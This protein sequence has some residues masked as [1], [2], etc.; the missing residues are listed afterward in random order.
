MLRKCPA[1]TF[2]LIRTFTA[3]VKIFNICFNQI[4]NNA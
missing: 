1:P 4:K 2:I 3:V